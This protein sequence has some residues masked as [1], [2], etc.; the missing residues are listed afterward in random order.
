MPGGSGGT[1]ILSSVAASI[2][3]LPHLL[4]FPIALTA[5]EEV[6][7]LPAALAGPEPSPR[8]AKLSYKGAM[9]D[10]LQE[11]RSLYSAQLP[12]D[13]P[14]RQGVKPDQVPPGEGWL[15]IMVAQLATS[16]PAHACVGRGCHTLL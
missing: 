14:S 11:S 10:G 6:L 3:L 1:S 7:P 5:S 13:A 9:L 16:H 15:S 8:Q 2:Q 12:G 4:G